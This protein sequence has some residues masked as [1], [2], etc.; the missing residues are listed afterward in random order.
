MYKY[1][2]ILQFDI[3]TLKLVVLDFEFLWQ[4]CFNRWFWSLL[5]ILSLVLTMSNL[6]LIFDAVNGPRT[7]GTPTYYTRI[8]VKSFKRIC[9]TPEHDNLHTEKHM[10]KSVSFCFSSI[11]DLRCLFC[12]N[13]YRDRFEYYIRLSEIEFLS[14][15]IIRQQLPRKYTIQFK[16]FS[17]CIFFLYCMQ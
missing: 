9:R 3:W 5:V 13:T 12:L 1:D 14:P 16:L 17:H 11:A 15:T 10:S 4:V 8:F 7:T 2:N 6:R